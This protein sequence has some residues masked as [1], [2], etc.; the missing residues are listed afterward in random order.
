MDSRHLDL[1]GLVEC[2]DFFDWE[3]FLAPAAIEYPVLLP[4]KKKPPATCVAGGRYLVEEEG[5]TEP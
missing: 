3:R 1:L 4:G 5:I 2:V